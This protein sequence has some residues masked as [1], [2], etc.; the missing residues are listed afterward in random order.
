MHVTCHEGDACHNDE[1]PPRPRHTYE[2]RRDPDSDA[3]A[4]AGRWG[5]G[6]GRG[7]EGCSLITGEDTHGAAS[8]EDA[9]V[10]SHRTKHPLTTRSS[11]HAPWYFPQG[12][13]NSS[14]QRP[15]HRYSQQL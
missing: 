15:A 6:W 9:V 10:V 7:A 2:N 3:G 8:L 11:D 14:P 12:A 5:R 13:E 4:T 1:T